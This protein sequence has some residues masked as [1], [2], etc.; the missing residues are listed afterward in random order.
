VG[1]WRRTG[2]NSNSNWTL[3]IYFQANEK[4]KKSHAVKIAIL[5]N[6]I[7]EEGLEVYNTF[8]I[9]Q[10]AAQ[11][12]VLFE[13]V[14]HAFDEYCNPKK[15][16]LLERC[17]FNRQKLE[18]GEP[19]DHFLTDIK[20]LV[21]SCDYGDQEDKILRDQIVFGQNIIVL[22]EEFYRN[23]CSE[24]VWVGHVRVFEELLA[25]FNCSVLTFGVQ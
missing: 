23:E 25:V 9:P 19:F 15:N 13:S 1:A 7:G 10:A 17:N 4:D 8:A 14:M 12:C 3:D 16:E 20:M 22:L 21:K 24:T 18:E 5:L 6:F 11:K 2:R